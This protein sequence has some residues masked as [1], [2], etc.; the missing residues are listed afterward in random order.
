LDRATPCLFRAARG[1]SPDFGDGSQISNS[2]SPPTEY[3]GARSVQISRA[4]RFRLVADVIRPPSSIREGAR[5]S[6]APSPLTFALMALP[7]FCNKNV[8]RLI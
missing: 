7:L 6:T 8:V 1:R 3:R 4:S 5:F 2:I